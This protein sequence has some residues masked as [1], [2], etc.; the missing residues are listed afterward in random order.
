MTERERDRN[1]ARRLVI[2]RYARE[3]TGNVSRTCRYYG[4]P[5][6]PTARGPA[7]TR[8]WAWKGCGTAH[9][10]PWGTETRSPPPEL[11][12][13]SMGHRLGTIRSPWSSPSFM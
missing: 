8:S 7:A 5:G 10:D 1:A 2:L 4:S 13:W 6:R 3:V 11:A 12:G 9:A